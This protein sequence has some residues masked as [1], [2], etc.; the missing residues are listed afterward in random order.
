MTTSPT[1]WTSKL[2]PEG[3][4]IISD[5]I[6]NEIGMFKDWQDADMIVEMTND[7]E[8]LP[9]L[10]EQLE[11]MEKLNA[12]ADGEIERLEKELEK[13]NPEGAGK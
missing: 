11:N 13:L 3:H 4:A 2:A 7:S 10:R 6:G 1:P 5:A 12:D 9:D 8:S